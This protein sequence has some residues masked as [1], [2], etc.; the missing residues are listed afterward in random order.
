MAAI[1]T[2]TPY[3]IPFYDRS[4]GSDAS[5]PQERFTIS[6]VTEGNLKD[7]AKGCEVGRTIATLN[8]PGVPGVRIPRGLDI[9]A[10]WDA[11]EACI[12]K[13]DEVIAERAN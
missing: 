11:I 8:A 13:A 5:A 4:P 1:L 3:E 10:F 2:G 12:Q 9:P 6:V 7:A